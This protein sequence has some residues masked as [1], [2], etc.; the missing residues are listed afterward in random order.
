M[1]SVLLSTVAALRCGSSPLS[2]A[3]GGT[4]TS[5]AVLGVFLLSA[6]IPSQP[7]LGPVAVDEFFPLLAVGLAGVFIWRWPVLPLDPL[8]FLLLVLAVLGVVSNV[9]MTLVHDIPLAVLLRGPGRTVFYMLLLLSIRAASRQLGPTTALAML[10]VVAT[11]EAGL[12]LAAYVEDYVGP[13]GE[14]IFHTLDPRSLF[15]A[16][17][18]GRIVGTFNLDNGKGMNGLAAFFALSLPL[19]GIWWSTPRWRP[20]LLVASGLILLALLLT[21]TRATVLALVVGVVVAMVVAGHWRALLPI[22]GVVALAS[23]PLWPRLLSR[24]A[25]GTDRLALVSAALRMGGERP[26]LGHGDISYTAYLFGQTDFMMT[27]FGVASASPHNSIALGFF[28]YGAPGALLLFAVLSL[29]VLF[30]CRAAWLHRGARPADR[31]LR[32]I[33]LCAVTAF[34]AFA[35]QSLTNNLLEVPKVAVFFFGLWAVVSEVLQ[36]PALPATQT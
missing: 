21:Y 35:V 7:F 13:Y 4:L 9:M 30:C 25:E 33:A 24:F 5:L 2:P 28:R 31:R 18:E 12:G 20:L 14:G 32:R 16:T 3:R 36:R 27:P 1:G 23:L 17:G 6:L 29:P 8:S 19:V 26:W 11:L 22:M 10:F 34:T 15:Y